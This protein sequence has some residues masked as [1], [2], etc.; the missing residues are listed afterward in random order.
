MHQEVSPHTMRLR[1]NSWPTWEFSHRPKTPGINKTTVRSVKLFFTVEKVI[2]AREKAR[3]PP[4]A[5][6][7]LFK[8]RESSLVNSLVSSKAA[9]T[10]VTMFSTRKVTLEKGLLSALNAGNIWTF[11]E[12]EEQPGGQFR[13][14]EFYKQIAVA[15]G[16]GLRFNFDYFIVRFDMGMKAV[17][18]AYETEH[19]HW[20]VIHPRFSRDFSFHFAVG[21][22]F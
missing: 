11:R 18:P 6:T 10:K 19:E 1:R 9:L 2:S 8:M 16:I 20:A 4:A 12:Y 15:Y 3:K 5:Q 17:N 14:N 22:P 7:Y 21:L 13:W